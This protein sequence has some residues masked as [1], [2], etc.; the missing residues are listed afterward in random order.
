MSFALRLSLLL[1]LTGCAEQALI[2]SD[3]D[4][5]I[6]PPAQRAA[7]DHRF[8]ADLK[9]A[10]DERAA[11]KAAVAALAHEPPVTPRTAGRPA[12][13]ATGDPWASSVHDRE[14]R[15]V[16]AHGRVEVAAAEVQRTNRAWRELWFEE[17]SAK[18]DMLVDQRQLTR[19]QAVD[20]NL[21]GEDTYDTAPLRGQLSRSQRRWYAL[22]GQ[23]NA[24][25]DAFD[26]ANANLMSAKEAYAQLMR[27]GPIRLPESAPS[28]A[29]TGARL[30]LAGWS[31]S[32]SDIRMR[33]GLRHLLDDAATQPQLHKVAIRLSPVGRSTAP[34][35]APIS[36]VPA[37]DNHGDVA[38]AHPA[39]RAT[40]APASA[41]ARPAAVA[42]APAVAA[43]KPAPA[44]VHPADRATDRAATQ[45]SVS[46]AARPAPAT[47]S[48]S[49]AA[50]RPSG[51]PATTTAR[52]EPARNAATPAAAIAP[53]Q[54]ATP[55]PVADKPATARPAPRV[56]PVSAAKPVE[57]TTAD[58][59]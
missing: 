2:V 31:V 37:D 58:S 9:A 36:A 44:V 10:L 22:S 32:R 45:T 13:A 38:Q 5:E 41:A 47:A 55:M 34:R 20:R 57:P 59:H 39:D 1:W 16:D 15:R 6:V 33:R 27:E 42:P 53:A 50:S 26:H 4:W 25:R 21:K 35:G 23:A 52:S 51:S 48:A 12:P 43:M 19:A 24:A 49:A 54:V 18:V 11:A 28:A 30:S 8:E 14:K 3:A 40:G 29:D 17:A 7:L 46:S 56:T